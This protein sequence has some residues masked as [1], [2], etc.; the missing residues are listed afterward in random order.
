MKKGDIVKRYK[1]LLKKR[2]NYHFLEYS[3]LIRY[4]IQEH[5]MEESLVVLYYCS[6][7]FSN[8]VKLNILKRDDFTSYQLGME[9]DI[10]LII[11]D[12]E[13]QAL[14]W[15]YGLPYGAKWEIYDKGKLTYNNKGK[16]NG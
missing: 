1:N 12:N 10:L 16:I 5:Y 3:D 9:S 15:A 4:F 13:K 2:N 11:L 8:F 14:D 7:G 6:Y